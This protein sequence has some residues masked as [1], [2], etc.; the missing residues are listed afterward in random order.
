MVG[1]GLVVCGDRFG[2]HRL[3]LVACGGGLLKLAERLVANLHVEDALGDQRLQPLVLRLPPGVAGLGPFDAGL[4]RTR[5]LPWPSLP[6][7]RRPAK[8]LWATR[9]ITSAFLTSADFSE[10]CS[11]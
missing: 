5:F 11:T 1:N 2:N 8:E 6:W 9:I 4:W 10:C 7:P 3:G